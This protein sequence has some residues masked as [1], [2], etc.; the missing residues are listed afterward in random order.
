MLRSQVGQGV[1]L[2]GPH[3]SHPIATV[4]GLEKARRFAASFGGERLLIPQAAAFRRFQ[5]D[6]EI[7]RLHADAVPVSE[8]AERYG[9]SE[10]QVFAILARE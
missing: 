6:Q 8:I 1:P 5:R 2:D 9:V 4:L 7:A 3:G 10:R